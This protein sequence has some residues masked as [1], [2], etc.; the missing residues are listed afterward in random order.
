MGRTYAL[1]SGVMEITY[2]TGAKVILQGPVTYQVESAR[3]GY[4][5]LGKLTARVEKKGSGS[6]G[7]RTANL[8]RSQQDR[9]PT[10]SLAPR[11]LSGKSEIR[12]PKSEISN[13]SPLAP[14]PSPLFSVRTPTAVVTDLGTEFGV[15]VDRSGTTRSHVFQ[16]RVEVR[17]EVRPTGTGPREAPIVLTANQSAA[18]AA[19]ASGTPTVVRM[20]THSIASL[21]IRELPARATGTRRMPLPD[22]ADGARGEFR[23]PRCYRLTDLGTLGGTT[24]K[25]IAINAAGQVVGE[26]TIA[27]G[28]THAFLYTDGKMKDLGTLDGGN[29]GAGGINRAGQVVGY[30]GAGRGDRRAFLY[31]DGRMKDIGT[32]GGP[33]A[34]AMAINDVG[35][36]VGHSTDSRGIQ[37]AFLYTSGEGMKDLGALGGAQAK[38]WA[39]DINAA[40][41]VVGIS[42]TKDGPRH[43]FLYSPAGGMKDLGALGGHGSAAYYVNDA[44]LAVGF[45]EAAPDASPLP[46]GYDAGTTFNASD[47]M[48]AFLYRHDAGMKDLGAPTAT[49]AWPHASITMGRW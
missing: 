3:S 6:K 14:R 17:P 43:A 7:E 2:D 41:L 45:V 12:N 32:L 48:R 9:V 15:E 40:G 20:P 16:G 10:T 33:S 27:T 35:Q 13:L 11:P 34:V 44:G 37:H 8:A 24:S 18:V 38:S 42:E 26:S 30:S 19:D 36:I 46:H 4:L 21:F 47:V 1:V 31:T 39:R 22:S 25:A 29:S 23:S 28:A 5:S 49:A